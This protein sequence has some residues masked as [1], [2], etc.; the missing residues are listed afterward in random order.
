MWVR[1]YKCLL[2]NLS[3]ECLLS[4]KVI[5]TESSH[6]PPNEV[7]AEDIID[8]TPVAVGASAPEDAA[9]ANAALNGWAQIKAEQ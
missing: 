1:T 2:Y 9:S 6:N 8:V 7:I 3:S 5:N 4:Y